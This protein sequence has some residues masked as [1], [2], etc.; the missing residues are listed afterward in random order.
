[1]VVKPFPYV[2][3]AV[4]IKYGASETIFFVETSLREQLGNIVLWRT[5]K[6][7]IVMTAA[8]AAPAH[9][10]WVCVFLEFQVFSGQVRGRVITGGQK[11]LCYLTNSN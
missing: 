3:T 4:P 2:S 5:R 1:M 9:T 10:R 7:E 6:A 8:A 11:F